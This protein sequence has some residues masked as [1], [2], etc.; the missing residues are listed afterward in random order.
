MNRKLIAVTCCLA[1]LMGCGLPPAPAPGVTAAPA[2]LMLG[3]SRPRGVIA[4]TNQSDTA[5]AVSQFRLDTQTRDWGS[6]AITDKQLPRE[7]PAGATRE[8]HLQAFAS[9]FAKRDHQGPTGTFHN[10]QSAL[11]LQAGADEVRVGVAFTSREGWLQELIA[12]ALGLMLCAV[13]AG[14]LLL[15][16]PDAAAQLRRRAATVAL[17]VAAAL[18]FVPWDVGI[19]SSAPPLLTV[20]DAMQCAA[21]RGGWRPGITSSAGLL[22]GLGCLAL[23]HRQSGDSPRDLLLLGFALSCLAPAWTAGSLDVF[24]LMAHQTHGWFALQHPVALVTGLACAGLLLRSAPGLGVRVALALPLTCA[25]TSLFFGGGSLTSLGPT[26]TVAVLAT[27]FVGYATIAAKYRR[28]LPQA[29]CATVVALTLLLF[30]GVCCVWGISLP[31]PWFVGMQMAVASVFLAG[32]WGLAEAAGHLSRR[33]EPRRFALG[34]TV[35]SF[36]WLITAVA[37][38]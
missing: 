37:I 19:C 27:G 10:G 32:V 31:Q 15:V 34:L 36:L 11:V 25:I 1:I 33:F 24:L 16:R 3:P 4:L 18:L 23:G 26:G 38:L 29:A 14:V 22:L 12:C 21:G 9:N 8:L 30:I 2:T 28:S 6:F 35:T 7:I 13:F 17:L 5:I 20:Q